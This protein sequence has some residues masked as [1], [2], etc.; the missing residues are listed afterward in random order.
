MKQAFLNL[1]EKLQELAEL[2]Y[3][4][5][6]WGQLDAYSPN[7][8][9]KFPLAL[10]DFGNLNFS[11]L[12]IDRTKTPYQRQ[13]AEGML[14]ITIANLKLTN[15]SRNAPTAQ[16]DA[17]FKIWELIEAVH[18]K[19]HGYSCLQNASPLIRTGLARIKRDDGIQEYELR[20]KLELHNV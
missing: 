15:T 20:Y 16:K 10:I 1:Q 13:M 8:P 6:D 5:E 9:T 17:A 11:N 12:G 3:I 14:I 4:D 2:K 7:P 19:L 18:Q